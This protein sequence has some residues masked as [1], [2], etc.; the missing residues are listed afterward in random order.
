MIKQI[1][2]AAILLTIAS[3]SIS[4]TSND[5]ICLPTSQLKK[6]INLIEKGKVTEEELNLT[7]SALKL[8]ENRIAVKDSI[9]LNLNNKETA[10]KSI[11]QNYKKNLENVA[12]M[13]ENLENSITLERKRVKRQ[14]FSKWVLALGGLGLGV[15]ITK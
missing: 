13:V 5:T 15:L 6:A 7:K 11:I 12:E 9:I 4:Q 1:I 3:E 2:S 10:Y 14:K 8:S